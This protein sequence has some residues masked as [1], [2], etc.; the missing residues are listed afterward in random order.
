MT[1]ASELADWIEGMSWTARRKPTEAENC[2]AA[3]HNNLP[4]ILSALRRVEMMREALAKA[5]VGMNAS[6]A[7]A[8][9]EYQNHDR[10]AERHDRAVRDA[11]A[12]IHQA[13]TGEA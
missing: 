9:A 10:I 4:E 8:Q 1:T 12:A 6:Y 2:M 13:L 5:R 7:M 3:I 11:Y